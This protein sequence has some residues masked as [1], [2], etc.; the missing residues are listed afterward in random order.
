[1]KLWVSLLARPP[2]SYFSTLP[3][4]WA[5]STIDSTFNLHFKE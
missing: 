1:M 3:K 5:G 2:P 4:C